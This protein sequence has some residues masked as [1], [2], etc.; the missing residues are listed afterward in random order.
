VADHLANAPLAVGVAV[1]LAVAGGRGQRG[2]LVALAFEGG[3]DVALGGD[4]GD[5]AGVEGCVLGFGGWLRH[6][7]ASRVGER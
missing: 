6:Q 3:D 2:E 4:L 7:A 5:V 1:G